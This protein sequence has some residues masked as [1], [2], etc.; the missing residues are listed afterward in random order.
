MLALCN[1]L[2]QKQLCKLTVAASTGP[3]TT[4]QARYESDQ[5]TFS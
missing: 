2:V 4:L 1:S 3:V 5:P